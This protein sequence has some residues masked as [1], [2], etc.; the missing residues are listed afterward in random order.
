MKIAIVG[1]ESCGKSTLAQDLADAL[2]APW[3]AEYVR[4]Y[5]AQKG[6]SDY[7]LSD[8]VAIAQGQL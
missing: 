3:V 1:P 2:K 8:I 7:Q 4:E 6:T 5:F